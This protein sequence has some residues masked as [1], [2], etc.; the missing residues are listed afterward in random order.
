MNERNLDPSR[1]IVRRRRVHPQISET[2]VGR[3]S[4]GNMSP[5]VSTRLIHDKIFRDRSRARR[6]FQMA[7]W[8]RDPRRH[9]SL[10]ASTSPDKPSRYR[11]SACSATASPK[12]GQFDQPDCALPIFHRQNSERTFGKAFV[13]KLG[14]EFADGFAMTNW[15]RMHSHERAVVRI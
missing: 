15:N 5:E 2:S 7:G 1:A 11:V 4:R 6:K 3:T 9:W 14:R 10:R 8:C 12:G 13:A